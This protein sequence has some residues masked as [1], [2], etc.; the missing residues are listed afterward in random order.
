MPDFAMG[1][2]GDVVCFP[3][4]SQQVLF[5]QHSGLHAFALA[6]LER[7]HA[8]AETGIA[9]TGNVIAI[10]SDIINL[11]NTAPTS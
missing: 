1:C 11:L 6:T 8:C 9:T 3:D 7:M 4:V 2:V 5:A 10:R